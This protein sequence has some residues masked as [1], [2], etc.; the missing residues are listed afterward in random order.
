MYICEVETKANICD[1]EVLIKQQIARS[2]GLKEI[3]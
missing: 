1:K 2:T 3:E